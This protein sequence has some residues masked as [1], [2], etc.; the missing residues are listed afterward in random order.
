MYAPDDAKPAEGG[1][2]STI[3]VLLGTWI[4]STQIINHK[5]STCFVLTHVSSLRLAQARTSGS[6]F[7]VGKAEGL[8]QRVEK[9]N[10][11]FKSTFEA[12]FNMHAFL[13]AIL[14]TMHAGSKVSTL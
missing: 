13:Y 14:G 5:Q 2:C 4:P 1:Q 6:S 9:V 12:M 10:K 8:E 11:D 7:F 3:Q